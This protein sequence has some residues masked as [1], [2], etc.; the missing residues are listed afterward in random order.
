MYVQYR[1]YMN[2]MSVTFAIDRVILISIAEQKNLTGQYTRIIFL[3]K[4]YLFDIIIIK[5]S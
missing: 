1:I 2:G 3:Q 5:A 4:L